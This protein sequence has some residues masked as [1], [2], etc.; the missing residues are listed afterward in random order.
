MLSREPIEVSVSI[1]DTSESERQK[2]EFEPSIQKLQ[3][4]SAKWTARCNLTPC[5]GKTSECPLKNLD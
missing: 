4:R 1:L 5:N 3:F 2:P